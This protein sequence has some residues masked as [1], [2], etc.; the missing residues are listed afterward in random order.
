MYGELENTIISNKLFGYELNNLFMINF[1]GN[2]VIGRKNI[3]EYKKKSK[4]LSLID[5]N[6]IL[7]FYQSFQFTEDG[8]LFYFYPIEES[9]KKTIFNKILHSNNPYIYHPFPIIDK[10]F[11]EKICSNEYWNNI[12]HTVL[13]NDEIHFR[14]YTIFF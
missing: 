3:S 2:I 7:G 4:S 10:F 5:E 6:G 14:K 8:V 9:H 12:C 13:N 11:K 1:D